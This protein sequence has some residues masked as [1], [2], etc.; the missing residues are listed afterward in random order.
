MTAARL[1]EQWVRPLR[2]TLSR[3]LVTTAL[4]AA[5]LGPAAVAGGAS[6][7]P[8][9]GLLVVEGR[10]GTT[11]DVVLAKDVY[12]R[13]LLPTF[14]GGGGFAVALVEEQ[15]AT[16]S[17][18]GRRLGGVQVRAF[19]DGTQDAVAPLGV[20]GH[21]VP[22]TYR[23]TL[24][25]Q[26]AV[27]AT[28]PLTDPDAPNVVLRPRTPLRQQFLARAEALE[29]GVT[30]G[31]VDLGTLAPGRRAVQVVLMKGTRVDDL[32][33]CATTAPQCERYSP[34]LG[35]PGGASQISARLE[36]A[37]PESRSLRYSVSGYRGAP[38]EGQ[39]FQGERLRAVAILY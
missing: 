16:Q 37:A 21:L 32:R 7:A 10:G 22:A 26:G 5:L 1:R 34:S 17:R 36:P 31:R 23:V 28:F 6:A 25:G 29:G 20:D 3:R 12:L 15:R 33:M 24:L 38:D 18:T 4:A 2:P 27:R 30:S 35:Q 14:E 9:R 39:T 13:S 11:V 19:G 8:E